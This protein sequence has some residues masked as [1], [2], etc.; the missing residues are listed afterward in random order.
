[1]YPKGY[2]EMLEQQQAWLVHGLQE[3]Y[4]R[5][6][7]GEGWPGDLLKPESNGHPL[8]HDLLTRL[9]ALDHSKGERFEENPEVMQHDLWRNGMTRQDSTDG[10][11]DSPHSPVARSRFSSD[12]FSSHSQQ[13]MPPTPPTYSPSS[14][15]APMQQ[16][17]KVEPTMS[18]APTPQSQY[19]LS[20]QGVVNPLALQGAP[21]WPGNNG[22]FNPFDE[23]DLMGSADYTNFNF[24]DP[25]PSPMFHR[26]MPMN[27]VPSGDYDDFKEFLNPNPTEITS[28]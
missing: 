4:R 22:G 10:S 1:V 12:A 17:I 14:R 5:S 9:G 27:C 21:Q 16:Q 2:V 23:M 26:Q 19:A 3:L 6:T 7:E 20:M 25:I 18:T 24:E 15:A 28:I 11:T 13:T 8:T